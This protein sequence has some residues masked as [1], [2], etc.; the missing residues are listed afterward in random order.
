MRRLL[1]FLI[2]LLCLL[3]GCSDNQQTA[4]A[5]ASS[6]IPTTVSFSEEPDYDGYIREEDAFD[7]VKENYADEMREWVL[8]DMIG[9]E[10]EYLLEEVITD[11]NWDGVAQYLQ[12]HYYNEIVAL[13]S[14]GPS[15]NDELPPD[16]P[17]PLDDYVKTFVI[18]THTGKFHRPD[19][20][21]VE[22]MLEHNK[23]VRET[24]RDQLIAEGY[25]P[26]G[27]CNP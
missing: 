16:E 15:H 10:F 17:P 27:N 4:E 24:T 23:K 25:S 3:T 18:N 6:T 19:C 5:S 9:G 12:T 20:S 8:D 1:L 21:S 2:F 26:C 14:D 13:V 7:Y 22:E 11:A